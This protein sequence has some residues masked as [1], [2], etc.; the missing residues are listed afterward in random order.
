MVTDRN[1]WRSSNGV[2]YK[3]GETMGSG[4]GGRSLARGGVRGLG[5]GDEAGEDSEGK[6]GNKHAVSCGGDGEN[7]SAIPCKEGAAGGL[8]G[9]NGDTCSLG[10]DTARYLSAGDVIPGILKQEPL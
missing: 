7:G 10:L 5:S 1:W 8:D 9:E 3:G 2:G 6:A 4:I